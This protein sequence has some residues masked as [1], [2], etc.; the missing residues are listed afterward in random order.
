MLMRAG[1]DVAGLRAHEFARLDSTGCAY[2]DYAGAALH[3]RSVVAR[4]ARRL[5]TRVMGNPHSESAPSRASTEAMDEARALTLQLLDADP[6]HYEVIFTANASGALRIVAD[7]FPFRTGSRL[8]LTAD[9]HNS[10]NGIR[11]RARRRGAIVAYTPLDAGLR[12]VEPHRHL[13]TASA[14]SLFAFPAQSNFSGVKHPLDWIEAAQVRGYRVLLDAAAY[15]PASRLSLEETPADF[16]ALS[17]Y[18]IFGYPT[19]VGAL[20]VRREALALLRR[21]YF[22]GGTVQ[23]VSVQNRRAR[24][25]N[26][27]SAFEDGTPSFLAMPAIADGL[28]WFD[29]VGVERIGEHVQR[30][31]ASLLGRLQEL[32]D[33]VVVYGPRDLTARGGTI[34]FN[35]RQGTRI[36][37]YELVERAARER[38]IAIRGGCF[39]NPGASESA[40]ALDGAR[41]AQ[42]LAELGPAF[43]PERFAECSGTAVGAARA[44]LGL[45]NNEEDVR[46]A[47]EVVASFS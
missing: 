3:P 11:V 28:R 46:R 38:G 39:C 41:I 1:L 17:F 8:V 20:V 37:D 6:G 45:A 7:A 25:H 44:S 35:L 43:T 27:A 36:V 29:R 14:P 26:G 9:N 10:V 23:F 24:L 5:T 4:D 31:T 18:K 16:V 30:C 34:A 12:G 21:S 22:G 33:R 42:C 19:G 40:F 13:T 2:L 32:G 47:L 15:L